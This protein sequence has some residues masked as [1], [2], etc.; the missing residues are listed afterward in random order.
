MTYSEALGG[1]VLFGGSDGTPGG[2]IGDTWLW[3]GE[4]WSELTFPRGPNARWGAALGSGGSNGA[5]ILFGG[6]DNQ[7]LSDTWTLK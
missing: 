6:N 5:A 7:F 1:I 2:H 3:D 4:T